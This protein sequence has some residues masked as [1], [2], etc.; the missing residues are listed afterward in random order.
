LGFLPKVQDSGIKTTENFRIL[1]REVFHKCFSIMLRPLLEKSDALYFGVK[2]QAMRFAARISLFLSDML[3]ANEITATY[4]SARS[5]RPCHTCMVSQNDLNN[6]NVMLE[7][8]PFRTHENMQE[9]I[10]EDRGKEFSVHSVKN[11]FWKFP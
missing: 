11:A 3:E 8:M 2:G 10:R 1:Q 6:M 5:K 4:K 9:I 7:D